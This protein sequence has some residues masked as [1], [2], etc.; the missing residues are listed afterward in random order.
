MDYVRVMLIESPDYYSCSSDED[1]ANSDI[2][3][4]CWKEMLYLGVRVKIT[5]NCNL[6]SLFEFL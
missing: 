1:I 6:F 4:P 2:T 3:S 5:L